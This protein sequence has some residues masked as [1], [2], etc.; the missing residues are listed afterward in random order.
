MSDLDPDIQRLLAS[1]RSRPE[2]PAALQAAVLERLEATIVGGGPGGSGG[3]NDGAP[4]AA[5]AGAAARVATGG[6]AI[7]KWVAFGSVTFALGLGS[8]VA[9]HAALSSGPSVQARA[10]STASAAPTTATTAPLAS[11]TPPTSASSASPE[12][13][14][15]VPPAAVAAAPPSSA[16]PPSAAARDVDLA[17]ERAG[18]DM[19]R[20]ALTRGDDAGALLLLQRHAREFPQGRLVEEREA[21]WVQALARSGRVGE[22]R[23]H[24]RAFRQRFPKSMLLPAVDMA[25]DGGSGP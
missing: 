7:A 23:A 1:E 3:G 6:G 15:D 18:I 9:L 2:E 21:L 17:A 12:P 13:E 5:G 8:G 14:P 25:V 10:A 4:T 19:A 11:A 20:T 24:A 22:A 16:R